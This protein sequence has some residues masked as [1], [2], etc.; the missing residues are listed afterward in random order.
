MQKNLLLIVCLL[1]VF[2]LKAQPFVLSQDAEI[3]VL[4]I[5]P[6]SSLNDAF[7]HNAFRI[8]DSSNNLDI[9]FDYGRYDFDAPNFYLNFAQGKLNY[10]IGDSR[11]YDFLKFYIW[12][13]RTVK[14]QVL[15]LTQTEKQRLL[16]YLL[17][18]IK[19]EN[20]EY[21]YDFFY[22][23]CATKI[24]DVLEIIKKNEIQ[25]NEPQG[26]KQETFRTLIQDNLN[27]NSW[28]SFGIDLALGS[29]IDKKATGYEFMFLP[30]FIFEF[31]GNATLLNS[32][33]KL[34]KQTNILNKK[35]KT[36]EDNLFITSP[37]AVFGIIG[38]M[39][40]FITFKDFKNQRRT[41]WL[42]VS[43]FGLTGIIGILILLLWFATD[44]KS[45]HQ[46]YN[47]LWACA[48]NLLVIYQLFR[49]KVSAW[50]VRYLKFLVI[51]L[52]LMLLHWI[53]GVQ[54]FAIGL[55]PFLVALIIRYLYLIHF[56]K[57]VY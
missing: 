53:L 50:F 39:V 24:R 57:K 54:V 52:C 7:G 56:F 49:K 20:K 34:V 9:V 51:L 30:K 41:H 17:N 3:S 42:D 27:R 23:N 29:V 48:L 10:S 14:E 44:H 55:I 16:S 19:P 4:T 32:D 13:N 8:K 43:L 12:Q 18:T 31:F 36:P 25:F 37:L 26:F 15:N 46:N 38:L 5:G 11:F 21:L 33:K 47:L 45:T 40:L 28:G 6:G 22:D 35:T 1:S 2:F